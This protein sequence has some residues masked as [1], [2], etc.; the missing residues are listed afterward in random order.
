[1]KIKIQNWEGEIWENFYHAL[2]SL[3]K[4]EALY[5]CGGITVTQVQ[6]IAGTIVRN[7][8]LRILSKTKLFLQLDPRYVMPLA[9]GGLHKGK[10]RPSYISFALFTNLHFMQM[11]FV[12]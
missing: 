6:A 8:R 10:A 3:V 2:N 12:G 4:T 11:I 7:L 1:M 9:I 5:F